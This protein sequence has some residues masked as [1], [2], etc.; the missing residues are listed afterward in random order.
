MKI[1]FKSIEF[2]CRGWPGAAR[3]QKSNDFQFQS[4]SKVPILSA[5]V[6]WQRP[7]VK[8]ATIFNP[9]PFKKDGL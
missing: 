5:G 7:G 9:D 2:D 8:K 4:F 3:G 1:L 6:G